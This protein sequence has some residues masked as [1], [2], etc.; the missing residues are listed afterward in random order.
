MTHREGVPVNIA[1]AF[2]ALITYAMGQAP[3]PRA[4]GTSAEGPRLKLEVVAP[5]E[6]IVVGGDVRLEVTLSTEDDQ[7]YDFLLG[8]FP[9]AFGIYVLG[10]WGPVPPAPSKVRP[11]NWMHQRHSAAARITVAKGKPYHTTVKLSDYFKVRDAGE[12]KPG[13]YQV[14]V[15]FYD[16]GLKMPSPID[17]GPV[18]FR[19]APRE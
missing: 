19:L 1:P 10:P 8:S 11:E 4:E 17:S 9:Q 2:V 7:S 18:R 6:C 3:L 5:A 15:K 12:F 14:N 13:G 16:T